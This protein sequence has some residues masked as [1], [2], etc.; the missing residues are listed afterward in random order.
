MIFVQFLLS[1]CV[2]N[3]VTALVDEKDIFWNKAMLGAI[4]ILD[5]LAAG[6]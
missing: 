1:V 4:L 2:L 3:E 5:D 6:N